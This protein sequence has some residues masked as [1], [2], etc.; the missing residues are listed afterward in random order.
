MVRKRKISVAIE[1]A[2]GEEPAK[3]YGPCSEKQKLVL[4]E[5]TVDILLTGGGESPVPPL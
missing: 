2:Y 3:V 5:N 1:A 4:I